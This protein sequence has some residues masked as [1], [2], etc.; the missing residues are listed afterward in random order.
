MNKWS[1]RIFIAII[2]IG[3]IMVFLYLRSNFK[4]YKSKEAQ[5]SINE[6]YGNLGNINLGND[7]FRIRGELGEIIGRHH[8]E[9]TEQQK[10]RLQNT[11]DSLTIEFNKLINK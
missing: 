10:S 6:F 1:L 5:K 4:A 8:S 9:M 7:Y 2:F 3:F 11:S